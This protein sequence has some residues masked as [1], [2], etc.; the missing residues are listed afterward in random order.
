MPVHDTT[1]GAVATAAAGATA[2]APPSSAAVAAGARAAE[3]TEVGRV[4]GTESSTGE[5]YQFKA[6]VSKVMDIIINS[7]YPDKD[8]VNQT[9]TAGP[10]PPPPPGDDAITAK[11]DAP[12]Y[13]YETWASSPLPLGHPFSVEQ[14]PVAPPN[15]TIF[16]F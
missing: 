1:Y 14:S 13:V 3:G 11:V 15:V 4:S 9:T 2:P 6:E 10:P 7:L 12:V 5:V 8:M 16:V